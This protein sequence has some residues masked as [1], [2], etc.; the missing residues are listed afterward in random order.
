ETRCGI[1]QNDRSRPWRSANFRQVA[2]SVLGADVGYPFALRRPARRSR[3]FRSLIDLKRATPRSVRHPYSPVAGTDCET[4]A[5]RKSLA[6]RC[7]T[8]HLEICGGWNP[9]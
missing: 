6:V 7:P 4:D 5:E 1:L 3:R 9:L 2:L 8:R